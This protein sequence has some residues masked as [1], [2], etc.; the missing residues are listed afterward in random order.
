M[1]LPEIHLPGRPLP[2]WVCYKHTF[3][4]GTESLKIAEHRNVSGISEDDHGILTVSYGPDASFYEASD[5]WGA[6]LDWPISLFLERRE[7]LR[8]PRKQ[9]QITW[10]LA[11]KIETRS[12]GCD[13]LGMKDGLRTVR[14]KVR[15]GDEY[16][17]GWF[18]D[19]KITILE[20]K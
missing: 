3:P 11:D 6:W 8:E 18:R 2:A 4:M 13:V 19:N 7:S 20:I 16:I 15:N 12:I 5:V 17:F 9:M 1:T 10:A 14:A